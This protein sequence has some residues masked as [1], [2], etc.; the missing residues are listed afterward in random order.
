MSVCFSKAAQNDIKKLES[1]VS[2]TIQKVAEL[3][4]SAAEQRNQYKAKCAKLGL[5][6]RSTPVSVMWVHRRTW[7]LKSSNL[8]STGWVRSKRQ[9]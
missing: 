6:V 4:R 1:Q 2:E 9:W 7:H 3:N 5:P 8:R